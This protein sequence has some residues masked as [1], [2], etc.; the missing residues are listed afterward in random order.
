M[1]EESAGGGGEDEEEAVA[2]VMQTI[3]IRDEYVERLMEMVCYPST[4]ESMKPELITILDVLRLCTV[5]VR[6]RETRRSSI[7]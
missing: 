6:E 3:Q 1:S 4:W 2:R 5:E 7:S